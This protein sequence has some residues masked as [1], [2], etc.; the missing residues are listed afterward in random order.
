MK[1]NRDIIR[2]IIN[3]D[4]FDEEDIEKQK[5][6]YADMCF[7]FIKEEVVLEKDIIIYYFE[8]NIATK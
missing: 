7:T 4:D 8:K 2:Y 5:E 6:H 3:I 1:T